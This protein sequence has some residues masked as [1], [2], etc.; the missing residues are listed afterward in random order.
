TNGIVIS[1]HAVDWALETRAYARQAF[2][3]GVEW[4]KGPTA[5]VTGQNAH[6]IG[7]VRK[8]LRQTSHRAFVHVHVQVADMKQRK[9]IEPDR[10]RFHADMIMPDLDFLGVLAATPIQSHQLEGR[11][12]DRMN[13]IPVLDVKE[14]D[15]LAKNLGFVIR[16]DS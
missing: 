2:E 7:H 3:R 1:Q 6:V 4:P 5:I 10:Q 14:I 15:A 12:N 11:S 13:R 16:L 9:A 8:K